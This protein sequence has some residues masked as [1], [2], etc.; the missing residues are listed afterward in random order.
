MV[1]LAIASAQEL[2]SLSM[3]EM[4]VLVI[5]QRNE[6]A[7]IRKRSLNFARMLEIA[8]IGLKKEP[9]LRAQT[10]GALLEEQ[11]T[12][13]EMLQGEHINEDEKAL[14]SSICSHIVTGY[15]EKCR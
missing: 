6:I 9:Q 4:R 3:Q 8:L 1:A 11:L 14:I 10:F 2:E 15:L 7:A 13:Q 12:D 5:Q